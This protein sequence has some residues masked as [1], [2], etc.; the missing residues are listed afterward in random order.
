MEAW[1]ATHFQS[2]KQW[3]E[4]TQQ[5]KKNEVTPEAV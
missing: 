2:T 1:Q 5:E 4:E 3:L